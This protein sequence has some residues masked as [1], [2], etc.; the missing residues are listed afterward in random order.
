MNRGLTIRLSRVLE[1]V[2]VKRQESKKNGAISLTADQAYELEIALTNA[3][4]N[5]SGLD[6]SNLEEGLKAARKSAPPQ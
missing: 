2:K 1:Q 4:L 6:Y 3:F 5:A